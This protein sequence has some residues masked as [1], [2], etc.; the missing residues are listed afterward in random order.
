MLCQIVALGCHHADGAGVRSQRIRHRC[1]GV[2]GII[3]PSAAVI[4][5]AAGDSERFAGDL[6]GPSAMVNVLYIKDNVFNAQLMES[7]ISILNPNHNLLIAKTGAEGVEL[8][9]KHNPDVM[10]L[11]IELPDMDGF[12]VLEQLSAEM[13]ERA[14]PAVIVTA[15]ATEA[16]R[17]R[18][19]SPLIREFLAK[20]FEI[21]EIA[22]ICCKAGYVRGA[23]R[24]YDQ[25]KPYLNCAIRLMALTVL[26]ILH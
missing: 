3:I 23:I 20:P 7:V 5:A 4:G 24:D 26:P 19:T 9:K 16:T 13:G 10:L 15:D 17:R 1:N 25:I 12:G 14:P 6:A 21:S 11:D 18:A 2:H 22:R 8:A